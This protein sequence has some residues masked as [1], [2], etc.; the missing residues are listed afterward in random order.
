M[1]SKSPLLLLWCTV[2]GRL[3]VEGRKKRVRR[4][5]GTRAHPHCDSPALSVVDL[6]H[7]IASC[8]SLCSD[9]AVFITCVVSVDVVSRVAWLLHL[10]RGTMRRPRSVRVVVTLSSSVSQDDRHP[11]QHYGCLRPARGRR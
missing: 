10:T 3:N 4:G 11:Q 1:P 2:L 8:R 5:E 7:C 6:L 9:A